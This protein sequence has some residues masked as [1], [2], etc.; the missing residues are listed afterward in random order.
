MPLIDCVYLVLS[1]RGVA[2]LPLDRVVPDLRCLLILGH[3]IVSPGDADR[4]RGQGHCLDPDR[5]DHG[6]ADVWHGSGVFI[7]E[8]EEVILRWVYGV[9][10]V[11]GG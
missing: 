8:M 3:G 1:T 5:G 7:K 10:A 9:W 6:S 4:I 11:H 2:R